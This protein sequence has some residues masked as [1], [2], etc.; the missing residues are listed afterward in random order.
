MDIQHDF[1]VRADRARTFQ[2]FGTPEGLDHWWT[3]RSNG[4]AALGG[5]WELFFD[6][7]Y[8][9]RAVVRAYERDRLIEWELT[10]ADPDWEG[11]R[12]RV[13]LSD[14]P[15][16]LTWVRFSHSGWRESNEHYRISSYCWAMY[17]RIAK[18]WIQRDE[19]V[20]YDHRLDV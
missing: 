19:V 9:W 10:R 20:P 14:H 13:E 6:E 4:E 11:T 3:R 8:D 16:G 2:A 17:L 12:V 7:R 1:P 18:H 15:G 5:L